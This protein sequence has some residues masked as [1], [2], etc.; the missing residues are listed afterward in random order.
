MPL[1]LHFTAIYN[2]TCYTDFLIQRFNMPNNCLYYK[3]FTN[4]LIFD[5]N[6]FKHLKI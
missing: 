5:K 2:N 1:K 3:L 4:I 6:S